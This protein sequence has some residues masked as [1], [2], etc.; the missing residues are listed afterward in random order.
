MADVTV[1]NDTHSDVLVLAQALS[2]PVRIRIL[3]ILL[4]GRGSCCV[5]DP[6]TPDGVCVCEIMQH[7]GLIQ[8][9]VSYHLA[10]LKA[11][12]LIREDRRGKWNYYS[13]DRQ[14][15]SELLDACACFLERQ[16]GI[17]EDR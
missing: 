4:Q 11:S 2:D 8:S 14:R 15:A 1:Q 5:S 16:D 17:G 13:I 7:L 10:K 3:E 12:G 6:Q 9:K